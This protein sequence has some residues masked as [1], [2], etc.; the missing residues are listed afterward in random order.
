LPIAGFIL[1]AYVC[2]ACQSV[3]FAC[4]LLCRVFVDN[5]EINAT[6]PCTPF[7]SYSDP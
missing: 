3:C 2:G 6:T 4:I 5:F 1:C 7:A